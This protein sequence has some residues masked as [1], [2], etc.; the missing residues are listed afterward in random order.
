MFSTRSSPTTINDQEPAWKWDVHAD[1]VIFSYEMYPVQPTKPI[2]PTKPVQHQ[3][4]PT[5]LDYLH[6]TTPFQAPGDL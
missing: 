4:K 5:L 1:G 2:Q 3:D 6:M